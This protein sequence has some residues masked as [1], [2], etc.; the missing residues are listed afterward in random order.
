MILAFNRSTISRVKFSLDAYSIDEEGE[1]I[2]AWVLLGQLDGSRT[3]LAEERE[4]EPGRAGQVLRREP[5]TFATS[6]SWDK[7]STV[8]MRGLPSSWT[9]EKTCK[10][11]KGFSIVRACFRLCCDTIYYSVERRNRLVA[12]EREA[13][14][15]AMAAKSLW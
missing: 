7:D 6:I 12:H 3:E 14:E 8:G 11:K 5:L 9:V 1:E 15:S 13:G 10:Q 2:E 4:N